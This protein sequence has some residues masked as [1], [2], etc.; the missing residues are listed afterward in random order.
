MKFFDFSTS[1]ILFQ[2]DLSKIKPKT[3]SHSSPLPINNVRINIECFAELYEKSTS[4]KQSYFVKCTTEML[5]VTPEMIRWW[6]VWHLPSSERYKLW[7]PRDHISARLNEEGIG[8]YL[9]RLILLKYGLGDAITYTFLKKEDA[10]Q[11]TI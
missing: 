1:F 7:H 10:K 3:V 8:Q 5:N 9:L 4:R 11:T 2:L 6:F